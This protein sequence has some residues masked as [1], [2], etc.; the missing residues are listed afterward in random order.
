M[1]REYLKKA[2]LTSSS[3]AADVRATVQDILDTIE[4]GGEPEALRYAAKFDRYEGPVVLGRE[5]IDAASAKVPDRLK[6]DI[7]F[8]HAN[9]KRFAEAQKETLKDI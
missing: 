1:P 6:R 9:V 7:Q 2:D 8:A 4:T 3:D 5:E